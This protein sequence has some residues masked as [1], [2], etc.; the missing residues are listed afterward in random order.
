MPDEERRA[1]AA[2]VQNLTPLTM[3]DE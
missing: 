3:S 1:V 2:A